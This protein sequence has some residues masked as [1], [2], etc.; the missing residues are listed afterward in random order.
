MTARSTARPLM[1]VLLVLSLGAPM[2]ALTTTGADRACAT[3]F[4]AFAAPPSTVLLVRAG[5]KFDQVRQRP[6][7]PA[8]FTPVEFRYGGCNPGWLV[9]AIEPQ[10]V[11]SVW[12]AGPRT[13]RSPPAIS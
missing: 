11:R 7:A 3:E 2:V 13:G 10:F 1:C 8:P 6:S 4:R 9:A 12:T 5:A